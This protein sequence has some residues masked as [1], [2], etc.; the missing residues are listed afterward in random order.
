MIHVYTSFVICRVIYFCK[1]Y[2]RLLLMLYVIYS[3]IVYKTYLNILSYC[4]CI[5]V[6]VMAT[7]RMS[8]SSDVIR[9][10]LLGVWIRFS[11]KGKILLS[12]GSLWF[13]HHYHYLNFSPWGD[14]NK[15]EE[16]IKELKNFPLEFI[17]RR[18]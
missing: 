10:K 2:I 12:V 11:L 4:F 1:Y 18:I 3:C 14:E 15:I 5:Y 6:W 16:W 17:S 7:F 9:L 8:Y 13:A